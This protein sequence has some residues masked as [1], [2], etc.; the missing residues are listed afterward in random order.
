MK[1]DYTKDIISNLKKSDA[2]KI[3]LNYL[4]VFLIQ[5][6]RVCNTLKEWQNRSHE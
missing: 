3:Q 1:L 4:C 2:W 5:W 6:W